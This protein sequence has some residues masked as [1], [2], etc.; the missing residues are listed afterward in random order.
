MDSDNFT[1]IEETDLLF[2]IE[3]NNGMTVFIPN[4]YS[5]V[6]VRNNNK[7]VNSQ[8]MIKELPGLK[9]PRIP[10]YILNTEPHKSLPEQKSKKPPN[11]FIIFRNDMCHIVKA[12]YP[13]FS[14]HEV[15]CFIGKLWCEL[16]QELKR[17]YQQRA[18]E[19][20]L[21]YQKQNSGYKYTY[22][23]K[24]AEISY[25]K[26]RLETNHKN[27]GGELTEKVKQILN[28][29]LNNSIS[30]ESNEINDCQEVYSKDPNEKNNETKEESFDYPQYV[31]FDMFGLDPSGQIPSYYLNGWPP[32]TENIDNSSALIYGEQFIDKSEKPLY[33]GMLTEN[34]NNHTVLNEKNTET[35]QSSKKVA[36]LNFEALMKLIA[37]DTNL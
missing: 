36:N 16:S 6:L 25:K 30:K 24:S 14:N 8:N 26:K 35:S 31:E 23:K 27:N 22:K 33:S 29:H 13:Q 37:P 4:E 2:N 21:E 17:E 10:A 12:K 28:F 15:S 5:P 32:S 3:N 11:S 9:I 19:I 20:K 7:T 18:K 1:R 34:L